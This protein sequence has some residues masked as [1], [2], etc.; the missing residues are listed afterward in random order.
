MKLSIKLILMNIAASIALATILVGITTIILNNEMERQAQ[1]SQEKSMKVAWEVLHSK[2]NDFRVMDGML[3][4]GDYVISN[5]FELVDKIK[6]LVGGTATVFMGDTRVSTNVKKSTGERAIGT[7]LAPGPVY[8]AVLKQGKSYRGQA[9]ILGVPYFTAYD[10]I[11]NASGD[12]VGILYVGVE[13]SEFFSIVEGLIMKNVGFTLLVVLF[14]ALGSY[15]FTT[16]LLKPLKQFEQSMASMT[17]GSG[18]LTH[19]LPV[20]NKNDELGMV[21]LS[22]NQFMDGLHRMVDNLLNQ[23]A[24]ISQFAA[25]FASVSHQVALGAQHQNEVVQDINTNIDNVTVSI[26]VVSESAEKAEQIAK[27]AG[28]DARQGEQVVHQAIQEINRIADSVSQIASTVASLGQRSDEISGIVQ[29][30]KEIADQTNLLALNAAIEAA[31]AGEQGRGFA[32]VADEVRKLAERTSKATQEI[33]GM[34]ST[35][36]SETQTA[37]TLMESGQ[38]QVRQ[39][40]LLANQAG[41]SLARINDG[42]IRTIQVIEDIA[43]ATRKGASASFEMGRSVITVKQMTEDRVE[44]GKRISESAEQLDVVSVMLHDAIKRFKV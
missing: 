7:K 38:A 25:G 43:G 18:D 14:S 33:G 4:N 23:S 8:D 36:Q 15:F 17:G 3:M 19:R 28:A 5:N 24:Q 21:A 42:S 41:E 40:V 20:S 9:D 32:V 37:V 29:V 34:I 2:G 35:I 27:E 10:P 39:G 1:N 44:I 6:E 12:V 26:G 30:I 11:K 22:F 31:R 16:V 13:K